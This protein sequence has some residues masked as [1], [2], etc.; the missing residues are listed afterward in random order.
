MRAY[1][2]DT[3]SALYTLNAELNSL[4]SIAIFLSPPS[5]G[6]ALS[7]KDH[8]HRVYALFKF[9]VEKDP[10]AVISFVGVGRANI[11]KA[12]K[13][14]VIDAGNFIFAIKIFYS[15]LKQAA[16]AQIRRSK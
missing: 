4:S 7:R 3:A 13:Y 16:S 11:R 9:R 2:A 1:I 6:L 10:S 12:E 15:I 8:G 5:V 14:S